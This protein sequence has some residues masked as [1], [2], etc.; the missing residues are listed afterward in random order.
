MWARPF[1]LTALLL[2]ACG[3]DQPAGDTGPGA[4]PTT[5]ETTTT[6]VETTATTVAD[7][8]AMACSAA[9]V[10][11]NLV[12]QPELPEPVADT[13]RRIAEA[14]A[15]C[16]FGALG[17][18]TEEGDEPFTYSFGDSGNPAGFWERQERESGREPL[19]FLVEVLERPFG[20]IEHHGV[21]RYAWPSAFTYN[22][23]RDVPPSERE[24]LKPL[25]DEDDFAGFEQFG[26]YI[27]YRA[28]ILEDG[29]WT[30]FVAGD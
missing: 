13:R 11:G 10:G 22:S 6:T 3:E 30:A 18:L 5:A 19:R 24:A 9:D 1:L 14:A 29:T 8:T 16:N 4:T 17:D 20:V 21:V 25:Y 15:D 27:G 7:G 12:E 23:W 26:G 28:V 2:A